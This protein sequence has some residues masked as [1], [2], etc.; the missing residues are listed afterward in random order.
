MNIEGVDPSRGAVR[1][2]RTEE[3]P[4]AAHRAPPG[5]PGPVSDDRVDLSPEA[6]RLSEESSDASREARVEEARR[7]M[8]SGE[9]LRREAIERA[10]ENL[11]RS[12]AL[13]ETEDT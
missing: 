1:P 9:L 8:E 10:A 4:E 12:G 3:R 5:R 6:R 7:K 13:D 11:L 2:E